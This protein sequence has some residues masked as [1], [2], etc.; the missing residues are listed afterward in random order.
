M[1]LSG[2]AAQYG[3]KFD[4]ISTSKFALSNNIFYPCTKQ[5]HANSIKSIDRA[6]ARFREVV[7]SGRSMDE[8]H[9]DNIAGGRVWTGEQA[10]HIGLVDEIGGLHRA[11]AYARRTYTSGDAKV[12]LYGED[13]DSFARFRRLI[14]KGFALL[15]AQGNASDIQ[16]AP[17]LSIIQPSLGMNGETRQA[18]FVL[19]NRA[20]DVYLTTDENAAILSHVGHDKDDASDM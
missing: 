18:P 12:E 3:V 15:T 17:L 2:A 7:A 5:M 11:I 6:Y 14:A 1:D 8:D 9:L 20:F 13:D 19:P 10:K 16:E 4:H